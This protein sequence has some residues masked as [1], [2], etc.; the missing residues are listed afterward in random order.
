M[1]DKVLREYFRADAIAESLGMVIL[2][3]A[4]GDAVVEMPVDGRHLNGMGHI[5][6]ASLF[7]LGDFCLAVASNSHGT[8]AVAIRCGISYHRPVTAGETLRATAREKH[9]G[10]R[11]AEYEIEIRNSAGALVASMQG[12]VFRKGDALEEIIAR[13]EG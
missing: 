4:N 6:G 1:D 8:S 5:H 7:A 13:R 2:E 12:M 10:K 3:G 11:I 9:F